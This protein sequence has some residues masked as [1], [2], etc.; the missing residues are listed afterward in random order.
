MTTPGRAV[1]P[2]RSC[3]N[4]RRT[5]T[6]DRAGQGGQV[7]RQDHGHVCAGGEVSEPTQTPH[8]RAVPVIAAMLTDYAGFQEINDEDL[9]VAEKMV[10]VVETFHGISQD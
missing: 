3:G 7:D 10:E 2:S 1:D 8:E 4:C 9:R 5:R 6:A